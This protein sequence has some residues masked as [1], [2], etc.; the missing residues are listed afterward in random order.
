MT[1]PLDI[2]RSAIS[3]SARIT[4]PAF[5]LAVLLLS[6]LARATTVLQKDFPDLVHEAELITVGT[7]V[8]IRE[9][10]SAEKNAP[11]TLVTFA[12]LDV[13]KGNIGDTELTLHFLG[14][15]IPQGKSVW[16]DG[17]PRFTLGERTV[18]FSTGNQRDFCP[19]VGIWQGVFRVGYD[20]KQGQETVRDHASV[21][22]TK[23]QKG[24]VY[25]H[26]QAATQSRQHPLPQASLPLSAFKQLISQELRRSNDP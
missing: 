8:D 18:L 5:L 19:L 12:N 21:P 17:V 25:K 9:Q 3:R 13:L 10:W 24:L 6:P 14:G 16:I 2:L 15:S 4:K 11:F 7:V 1:T 20:A 23:V 22:I 26:G